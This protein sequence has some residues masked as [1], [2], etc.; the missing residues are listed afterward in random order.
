VDKKD[1]QSD[2][3]DAAD[4]GTLMTPKHNPGNLGIQFTNF[5]SVLSFDLAANLTDFI[6]TGNFDVV[7]YEDRL[8]NHS[9]SFY[10]II[11][12]GTTFTVPASGVAGFSLSATS[13]LDRV[14]AVSG[15]I[16]GWHMFG[17]DSQEIARKVARGE[18]IKKR[19]MS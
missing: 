4:N 1:F 13:T 7:E 11:P 14:V 8:P 17:E 2:L 16:Q 19:L 18:L 12:L 10:E 15:A 6:T 5:R 3:K 9:P